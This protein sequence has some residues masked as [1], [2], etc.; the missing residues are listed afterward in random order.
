M[1]NQTSINQEI[2]VDGKKVSLEEFAIMQGNPTKKL[3]E[4]GPNQY[5]LLERVYG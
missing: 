4:V 2:F 1:D 5:K 3:V